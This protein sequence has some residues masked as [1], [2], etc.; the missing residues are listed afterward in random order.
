LIAENIGVCI[1]T[2]LICLPFLHLEHAH[3]GEPL[4]LDAV[5]AI[6]KATTSAIAKKYQK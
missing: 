5:T 2:E 6:E 4:W 3:L 1:V